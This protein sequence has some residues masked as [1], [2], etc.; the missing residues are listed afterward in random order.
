MPGGSAGMPDWNQY[1]KPSWLIIQI[2]QESVGKKIR[3]I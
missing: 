3:L 2:F 1:T